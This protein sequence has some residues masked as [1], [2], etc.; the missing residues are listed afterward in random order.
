MARRSFMAARSLG[1]SW[2]RRTPPDWPHGDRGISAAHK[3][4]PAETLKPSGNQ[5]R[6]WMGCGGHHRGDQGETIGTPHYLSGRRTGEGRE[7]WLRLFTQ[8]GAVAHALAPSRPHRQ[9][10]LW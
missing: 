3:S 7:K 1:E 8:R 9:T 6:G 10:V 4:C 5:V 2:E